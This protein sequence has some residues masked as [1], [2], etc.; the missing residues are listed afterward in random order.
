M[1]IHAL[2]HSEGQASRTTSL[3]YSGDSGLD[4][5][6][7]TNAVS[8]NYSSATCSH[9]SGQLST[10]GPTDSAP[11]WY[12]A[13]KQI[14]HNLSE[15][16]VRPTPPTNANTEYTQSDSALQKIFMKCLVGQKI[17]MCPVGQVAIRIFKTRNSKLEF[18]ASSPTE[19]S[20]Y[21]VHAIAAQIQAIKILW[22]SSIS[23]MVYYPEVFTTHHY[24]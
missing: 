13:M 4:K 5:L 8:E 7:N 2:K 12:Q 20:Q 19:K 11:R 14:G 22:Y 1:P 3:D 6:R 18:P 9:L 24:P 23:V 16:V 21:Q 10:L 15:E 17:F